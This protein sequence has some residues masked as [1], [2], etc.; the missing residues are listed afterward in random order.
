MVVAR[1]ISRGENRELN[2]EAILADP[3]PF[4]DAKYGIPITVYIRAW[5]SA[6]YNFTKDN[7][8]L[9]LNEMAD[10][11]RSGQ[12]IR[13]E[14][15]FSP[16]ILRPALGTDLSA[17][18]MLTSHLSFQ[19]PAP[20]DYILQPVGPAF[21]PGLAPHWIIRVLEARTDVEDDRGDDER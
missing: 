14:T 2:A 4:P 21:T 15:F 3:L 5:T 10:E 8:I 17:P 20:G 13:A 12:F 16:P 7:R 18:L 1:K 19:P 9:I 11:I 6:D